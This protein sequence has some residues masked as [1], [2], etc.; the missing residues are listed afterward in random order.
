MKRW[1]LF[2]AIVLMALGC[3][4]HT[5]AH[6]ELLATGSL[7]EAVY[8]LPNDSGKLYLTVAGSAND[9]K[10]KDLCGQF[11]ATPEWTEIR[12][13]AHYMQLPTNSTMFKSRYAKEYTDFPTIRV[14][15]ADGQIV[16]EWVGRGIPTND[17][18]MGQLKADCFRRFRQRQSSPIKHDQSDEDEVKQPIDSR[19]SGPQESD[20]PSWRWLVAAACIGVLIGVRQ[21]WQAAR[22]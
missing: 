17:Q 20:W 10:Y 7:K 6:A 4:C 5:A 13:T 19:P 16:H 8:E 2:T 15:T 9:Q 21:D 3:F 14:Q 22:A 1:C 12:D 18:L 11:S